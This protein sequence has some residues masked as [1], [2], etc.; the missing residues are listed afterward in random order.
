[1][2]RRLVPRTI[3]EL[4]QLTPTRLGSPDIETRHER[5]QLV[6]VSESRAEAES[7][8]SAWRLAPGCEG[9]TIQ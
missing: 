7:P 5:T 8:A 6:T 3:T 1:M 2:D 4:W 9:D